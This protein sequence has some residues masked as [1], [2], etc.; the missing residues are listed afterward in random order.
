[1]TGACEFTHATTTQMFSLHTGTWDTE[2][3]DAL[4]IP[5]A[6]SRRRAARR[7]LARIRHPVR[8]SPRM[9]RRAR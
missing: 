6:I 4:G 3:L 7:G 8:R 1:M 9:T 5:T 2:T